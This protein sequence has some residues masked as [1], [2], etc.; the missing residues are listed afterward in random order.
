MTSDQRDR[1]SRQ[2]RF[3]GIGEAGQERLLSG[4][5]AIVGCGAL[6]SFQ[7]GAL[8]RA[9]CG[10]L[11]LIDRDFV[12]LSNLQRQWLYYEDDARDAVP[13]AVAAA[14]RIARINSAVRVSPVV[15]DL[16]AENIRDLL[17]GVS[18]IIDGTDNFETRYLINDFAVASG[19]PWVYGAAVAGYGLEMPI[20]P[21]ATAC[22]KCVFPEPPAA[23][24]PTCETAGIVNVVTSAVASLQ[25]ADALKIICG[26]PVKS[27]IASIDL[28]N[29]DLRQI[30]QPEPDPDCRCCGQRDFVHLNEARRAPVRLCGSN[31]VQIHEHAQAIDLAGLGR[32]L[33]SAGHVRAN[34]FAIR[35]VTPPYELTIFA[36]GRAI[37]KGTSDVALARSLYARYVGN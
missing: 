1:Y 2:I 15:V 24:Q 30:A 20:V 29:G 21:G 28:W 6:G 34:E 11:V 26:Q 9:G 14:R 36:D 32:H 23:G 7:A 10:S 35:F 5:A 37:V 18:V 19:I 16:T 31:A 12:E 17:G 4:S 3:T 25:V 13:K 22:L 27:R 33:A 8:A